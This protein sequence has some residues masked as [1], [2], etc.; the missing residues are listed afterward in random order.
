MKKIII[1]LGIAALCLAACKQAKQPEYVPLQ[2]DLTVLLY[3]QGQ[4]VDA[5]IVENGQQITLGPGEDNGLRGPE[6]VNPN[7]NIAN[8]GD[9]ARV[10][11]YFPKNPNGLCIV[12]C[13]GGGYQIV[14]SINEGMCAA[15]W[16]TSQGVTVC[17]VNYR[18]PNFHRTVPLTDVQ[19]AFRYCRAHA[20]EWGISKIGVMGY[21]AGGH[22]AATASTLYV[23]DVTHPDFSV[24]IYP[25]IDLTT[26]SITHVGTRHGLLGEIPSEDLVD[27]YSPQKQVTPETPETFI[28][29]SAYDNVVPPVNSFMYFQAL[30][31]H[32][33][34]CQMHIY[35]IGGHGW[36]FYHEPYH[37][38][39]LQQYREVFYTDLA[40]FLQDQL[41]KAE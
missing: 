32:N 25:V 30:Q 15:E 2:P 35:P 36:G 34:P 13:P 18:L 24:L 39:G 10:D 27:L 20:Q 29:L 6:V 28:A 23:D 11:I 40:R 21:S 8:I 3:P 5:G 19:N 41:P 9:S 12:N 31:A 22:L 4:A 33:V 26:L 1:A 37:P 14:S 38:D 16:L 17:S 7:G